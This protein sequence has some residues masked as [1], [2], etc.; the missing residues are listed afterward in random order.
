MFVSDFLAAIRADSADDPAASSSFANCIVRRLVIAQ[1]LLLAVIATS[2]IDPLLQ[3]GKKC[4]L[5][6][7]HCMGIAGP[8]A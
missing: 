4:V 5:G 6:S 8:A 7:K 2:A 3:F 1:S